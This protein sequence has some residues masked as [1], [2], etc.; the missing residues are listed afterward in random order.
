MVWELARIQ[1]SSVRVFVLTRPPGSLYAC[2]IRESRAPPAQELGH[3]QAW[4]VVPQELPPA[5]SRETPE[6]MINY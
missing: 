5:S 6:N 1:S 2:G 4:T 3:P